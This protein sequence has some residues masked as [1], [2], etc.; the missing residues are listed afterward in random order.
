MRYA[1]P[2]FMV[3]QSLAPAYGD[4]TVL[5]DELV[6]RY[7]DLMLAPG[8]R[9]AMITRMEQVMLEDP[10]PKLR[11]ILAPTLLLWGEKD[12]MIP[13]TNAADYLRALPD[14]KLATFPDLGHVPHEEAPDRT[15]ATVRQFLAE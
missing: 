14:A 6:T 13:V 5:T 3:R 15:L 4:P 10:E 12:A 11:R 7:R 1:L 9:D 2:T 8:V